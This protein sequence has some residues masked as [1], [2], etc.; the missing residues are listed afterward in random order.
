MK[1]L[2]ITQRIEVITSYNERRDC[3]DQRWSLFANRLGC[4]PLPLAN[5]QA[6]LV[7][8][9][10]GAL[11]LCGLLLSGGNSIASLCPSADDAAPE[12][13]A[14]EL[15]IISDA[16]NRRIPI[17]AICRGMQ[18]LNIYMG[19]RLSPIEG[20]AAVRHTLFSTDSP[21]PL[22]ETVN[23]YHNWSIA[24]DDLAED[25]TPIATDEDGNIEA[26][27]NIDNKL[28]G[29]MWHP[30]REHPFSEL[31]IRLIEGFLS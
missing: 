13:D 21:Q 23:S 9:Y 16:L 19:G 12:R 31:D 27:Q 20:H 30:E 25:L 24:P 18:I 14:F 28:L 1:R 4:F 29:I 17:I 26:F 11:N 8:D 10:L 3:L 15:A 6:E 5:I 7:P 2:G 22:P